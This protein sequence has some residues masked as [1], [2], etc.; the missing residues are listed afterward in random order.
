VAVARVAG[1]PLPSGPR[2]TFQ[3]AAGERLRRSTEN[4][5]GRC[6]LSQVN[7]HDALTGKVGR[8][9]PLSA[10]QWN[11]RLLFD[12]SARLGGVLVSARTARRV[13]DSARVTRALA[14]VGRRSEVTKKTSRV[15]KGENE[16]RC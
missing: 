6:N 14:S 2:P 8:R 5:G 15:E 1:G 10:V 11:E 13:S 9:G 3:A 12:L 4:L 16:L 7:N